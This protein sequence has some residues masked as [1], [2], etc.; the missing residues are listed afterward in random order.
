V[1]TQIENYAL[2]EF[3][4]GTKTRRWA[5]AWSFLPFRP[6]EVYH[7]WWVTI[8]C[9][10]STGICVTTFHPKFTA[11]YNQR[12]FSKCFYSPNYPAISFVAPDDGIYVGWKLRSRC[13][14]RKRM[15][16]SSSP[17][18]SGPNN[19]RHKTRLSNHCT[20]HRG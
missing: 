16:P 8:G 10:M 15:V 4:Q 18:S 9:I 2:G 5:I 12:A 3:V 6:R 11:V 20:R 1:V 17:K 13:R 7:L 19:R 14:S